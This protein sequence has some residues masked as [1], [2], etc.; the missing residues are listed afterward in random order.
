M[1]FALFTSYYLRTKGFGC[2]EAEASLATDYYLAG[3]VQTS[4]GSS[5]CCNDKF[6]S[7]VL[8]SMPAP[9]Y[10]SIQ[11][12]P[13]N[14]KNVRRHNVGS[15]LSLFGDWYDLPILPT[16]AI[17]IEG[18]FGQFYGPDCV[19]DTG[20]GHGLQTTPETGNGTFQVYP[21]SA[22]DRVN[23]HVPTPSLSGAR[24]R[25]VDAQGRELHRQML[26]SGD[27]APLNATLDVSGWAAGA[28]WVEVVSGEEVATLPFI[29][30]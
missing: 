17:G 14:T 21:T 12:N 2:Y 5:E 1:V 11:N 29:K 25:V 26:V 13:V 28:Y 3:V 19:W 7:F 15:F 10:S 22:S 27:T 16:G 8:G 20:T 9:D 6:T 4:H 30:I 23:V 18:D 24:V